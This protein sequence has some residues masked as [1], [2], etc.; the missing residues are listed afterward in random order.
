MTY[1]IS[2]PCTPRSSTK[3]TALP[4]PASAPAA[5]SPCKGTSRP[6]LVLRAD[7]LILPNQV[8]TIIVGA[9]SIVTVGFAV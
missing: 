7:L 8:M 4:A 6:R 5:G 2:G 9:F 1:I 3:S